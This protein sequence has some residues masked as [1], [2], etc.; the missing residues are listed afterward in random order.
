[1][2]AWRLSRA[3]ACALLWLA[4]ASAAEA[5][6]QTCVEGWADADFGIDACTSAIKSGK[7]KDHDL[8]VLYVNRGIAYQDIG[9]LDRAIAD[10]TEAIRLDPKYAD[11][12]YNRGEA[13]LDARN[14]DRAIADTSSVARSM[15]SREHIIKGDCNLPR[16]SPDE[17]SIG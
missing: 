3:L 13:W 2:M 12:Y 1:M 9:D 8:A 14:F 10:L 4:A 5:D 6:W 16:S 7:Y 15:S 17:F 11:A